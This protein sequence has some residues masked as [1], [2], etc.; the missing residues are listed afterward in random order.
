ML[1]QAQLVKIYETQKVSDFLFN[2]SKAKVMTTRD[3][4]ELTV[5]YP[6]FFW[7]YRFYTKFSDPVRRHHSW[8]QQRKWPIAIDFL[9]EIWAV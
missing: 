1:W 3:M 8:H 9:K 4:I 7:D 5:T 6:E 2:M